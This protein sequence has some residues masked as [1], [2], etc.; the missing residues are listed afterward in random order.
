MLA[1]TVPTGP[2]LPLISSDAKAQIS[3]QPSP[4]PKPVPAGEIALKP[5][6]D[7]NRELGG[8]DTSCNAFNQMGKKI[9]SFQNP[10]N[11]IPMHRVV[12][13]LQIHFDGTPRLPCLHVV[14]Y[15]KF[16]SQKDIIFNLLSFNK[17]R[18]GG[19]NDLGSQRGA[20]GGGFGHLW[21]PR[22]PQFF[23]IFFFCEI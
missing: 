22:P 19:V 20:I 17:S 3:T 4:C 13:F 8:G 15:K 7:G 9:N 6:I 5:P 21:C 14:V 12:G 2:T 11:E 10:Q 1:P 18:L 23:F 16:L